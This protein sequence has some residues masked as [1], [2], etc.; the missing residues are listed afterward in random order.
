MKKDLNFT[1]WEISQPNNDVHETEQE[2]SGGSSQDTSENG[3]M[4]DANGV[5]LHGDGL[6][7]FWHDY[8]ID[9]L[10][11]FVCMHTDYVTK[12]GLRSELFKHG[13]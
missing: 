1:N 7:A 11:E 5:V 9:E 6:K 2:S 8:P 12:P 4:F 13:R 10:F 3:E